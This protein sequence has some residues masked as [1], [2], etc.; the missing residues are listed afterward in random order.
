[1]QRMNEIEGIITRNG[2]VYECE[3]EHLS[4]PPRHT[5]IPDG[6]AP[7]AHWI[8]ITCV[9]L[10]DVGTYEVDRRFFTVNSLECEL[11]L[12]SF[13][14]YPPDFVPPPCEPVSSSEHKPVFGPDHPEGRWPND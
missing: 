12:H 13:M 3:A 8:W 14:A 1:M 2:G 6:V 7:F 4:L 11:Q 10:R 5:P 9:I